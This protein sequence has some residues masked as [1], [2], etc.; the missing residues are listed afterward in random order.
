MEGGGT[1]MPLVGSLGLVTRPKSMA[2]KGWGAMIAPANEFPPLSNAGDGAAWY[3]PVTN[4]PA[5]PGLTGA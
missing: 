2:V 1:A 4:P 3:F 5:V